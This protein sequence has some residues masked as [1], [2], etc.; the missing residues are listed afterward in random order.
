[1]AFGGFRPHSSGR[2]LFGVSRARWRS[3]ACRARPARDAIRRRQGAEPGRFAGTRGRHGGADP[4]HGA[5]QSCLYVK[6]R[7]VVDQGRDLAIHVGNAPV[8]DGDRRLAPAPGRGR[9]RVV[10]AHLPDLCRISTN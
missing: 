6:L 7:I 5:E 4:R 3:R 8:E 10:P 1:M 2:A 9:A